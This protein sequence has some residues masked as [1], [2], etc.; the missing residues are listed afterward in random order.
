M[1]P[2]D[3]RSHSIRPQA[4]IGPVLR[5]TAVIQHP[6]S[7]EQVDFFG[8]AQQERIGFIHL[9]LGLGDNCFHKDWNQP[10]AAIAF[11]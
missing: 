11:I 5:I 1:A 3:E 10:T 8:S 6:Q 2:K 4:F 7:I 9:F